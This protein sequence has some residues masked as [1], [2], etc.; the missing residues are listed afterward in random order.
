MKIKMNAAEIKLDLFR[1]IDGLPKAEL[2]KFYEKVLAILNSTSQY[3]LSEPEKSAIEEAISSK[4]NLQTHADVVAE[5]K[6]RYPK[7]KFK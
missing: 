7:L 3:K 4:E 2:E 5:A 6:E 1:R